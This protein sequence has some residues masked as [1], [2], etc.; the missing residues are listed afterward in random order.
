MKIGDPIEG[1]HRTLQVDKRKIDGL[2]LIRHEV[3]EDDRGF[4]YEVIHHN[5]FF[6]QQIGQVYI[7]GDPARFTIR[8]FH[9]HEKIHDWF[10]IVNGS[11]KFAFVDDRQES[12]TYK[13]TDV[14][15][16]SSRKPSL[17]VV[18]PGVFHGWMSLEDN[19][20]MV[21]IASHVYNRV[22]PDEIRV[23][24]NAFNDLFGR[25]IWRIEAK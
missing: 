17:I 11:S 10:C 23:P 16:I 13:L 21:S 25:D 7:V 6:V 20:L 3:F 19:T 12:P 15:V 24:A 1:F 8:A 22:S 18:P 5:D 9:K 4:L 14:F 2:L